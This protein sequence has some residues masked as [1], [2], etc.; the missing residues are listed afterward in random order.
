MSKAYLPCDPDQQ[1]LLSQT[2]QEW[3]PEGHL[4]YFISDIVDQLDLLAITVRCERER[5]GDR[6]TILG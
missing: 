5:R 3:P 1:L 4:A 2:L 6:P